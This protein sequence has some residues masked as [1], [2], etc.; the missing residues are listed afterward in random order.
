MSRILEFQPTD[1]QTVIARVLVELHQAIDSNFPGVNPSTRQ[2]SKTVLTKQNES[3]KIDGSPNTVSATV[4]A[5]RQNQS[6]GA[7]GG[8]H[9]AIVSMS[10]KTDHKAPKKKPETL[11][12]ADM[13]TLMGEGYSSRL[14]KK[15]LLLML[16]SGLIVFVWLTF[17][18]P[19][20]FS[21]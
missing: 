20:T 19:E 15:L 6:E 2:F 3:T 16:I 7:N 10:P 12:T 9:S 17:I 13:K 21:E 8:D 14:T 11:H 5:A 1:E 18:R 4:D